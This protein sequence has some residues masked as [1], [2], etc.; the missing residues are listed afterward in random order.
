MLVSCVWQCH[1]CRSCCSFW[2][3][4]I[5]H[6]FVSNL[7]VWENSF[8]MSLLLC[9]VL[10]KHIIFLCKSEVIL[11]CFVSFLHCLVQM[12][13]FDQSRQ[14]HTI[15][16]VCSAGVCTSKHTKWILFATLHIIQRTRN[17][18]DE[19]YFYIVHPLNNQIEK[20]VGS[21]RM[22]LQ[23]EKRLFR[24][25]SNEIFVFTAADFLNF[26]KDFSLKYFFRPNQNHNA[27]ISEWK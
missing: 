9:R 20:M 6:T 4:Y 17:D 8:L 27:L 18:D 10:P 5:A 25:F 15:E 14:V 3:S 2:C 19:K 22:W 23:I 16:R 12:Y 24:C 11:H 21:S 13:S 1:S 26:E 7:L